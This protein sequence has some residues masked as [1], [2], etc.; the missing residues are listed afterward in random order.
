MYAYIYVYA[1]VY[2]CACV[3]VYE[4]INANM[5]MCACVVILLNIFLSFHTFSCQA[6]LDVQ[7]FDTI[8][9]IYI[10]KYMHT[11]IYV[12]IHTAIQVFNDNHVT[13]IYANVAA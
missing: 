11:C 6:W 5:Y 4:Y 2:V 12:H 8:C 3:Y 9:S 1:Y 13:V 7:I 10:P